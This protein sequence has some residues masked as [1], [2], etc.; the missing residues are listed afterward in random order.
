[1]RA[2]I[3]SGSGENVILKKRLKRKKK[4]LERQNTR[5]KASNKENRRLKAQIIRSTIELDELKSR[6][7]VSYCPYCEEYNMF[8]WEP[9]WGIITYCP[10]CGAKLM[11][12][13]RCPKNGAECDYDERIDLCSE[14]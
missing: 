12:C 5:L 9:E 3:G 8:S 11:L 4:S 7:T 2:I 13:E 10:K 14:M 6:L 1:M